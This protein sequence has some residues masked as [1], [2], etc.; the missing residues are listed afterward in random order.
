MMQFKQSRCLEI[1]FLWGLYKQYK[2]F[3]LFLKLISTKIL[4][5]LHCDLHSNKHDWMSSLIYNGRPHPLSFLS[6]LYGV[7][8]PS[9]WFCATLFHCGHLL[10]TW[11]THC[12]LKFHFGQIERSEIYTEVSFTSPKVMWSLII[13]LPYT[14]VKFYHE[15]KS[16]PVWVHFGSH[17]HV[18]LKS[19]AIFRLLCCN[20]LFRSIYYV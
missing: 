20:C 14:E 8:E 3:S 12:R 17:I 19:S 4:S 9:I 5:I 18:L 11:K 2:N 1:E 6:Y 16:P 10:F 13:K 15:V 7:V